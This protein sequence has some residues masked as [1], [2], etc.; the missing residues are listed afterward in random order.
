MRP[1]P[2]IPRL[3]LALSLW[4]MALAVGSQPVLAQSADCVGRDTWESLIREHLGRYA[5]MELPDLYKLLHQATM[6]SEHAVEDENAA[7]EWLSRE[8]SDLGDGP[9]EPLIDTLG[10]GGRLVRVH[11]RPFRARGGDAADLLAAF[12]ATAS[13]AYGDPAELECALGVARDM[14]RRGQLPWTAS[15]VEEYI[16]A[17]RRAGFPAEHHSPE[18]SERY[19]PA[20]RVIAADLIPSGLLSAPVQEPRRGPWLP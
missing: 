4:V 16:T 17:R 2:E 13:G 7:E 8:L 15:L 9:P 1:N 3:R 6:G 20:Y 19:R 14:A 10:D 5:A 12:V 18:Y 11:L